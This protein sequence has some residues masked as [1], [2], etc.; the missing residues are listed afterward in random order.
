DELRTRA[1]LITP[2]GPR[3]PSQIAKPGA[4]IASARSGRPILLVGWTSR[5]PITLNSWDR[6][7]IPR[8][9]GTV[10]FR[11][12]RIEA[13]TLDQAGRVG[14]TRFNAFSRPLI[15]SN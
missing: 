14:A 6:M 11:C 12:V 9:F 10:N 2:D 13:P 8:P 7:R 5:N 15:P 4:L 3:G 1:C